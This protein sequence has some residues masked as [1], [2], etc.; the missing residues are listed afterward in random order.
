M[1]LQTEILICYR[2]RLDLIDQTASSAAES[3]ASS[4]ESGGIARPDVNDQ[5][6]QETNDF[7]D[8]QLTSQ[9]G[10]PS[11]SRESLDVGHGSDDEEAEIHHHQACGAS[12]CAWLRLQQDPAAQSYIKQHPRCYGP[13]RLLMQY[14]EQDGRQYFQ[15][16]LASGQLL[17]FVH[18][19]VSKEDA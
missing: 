16:S 2:R 8:Q 19:K 13:E 7:L 5:R 15:Y 17:R 4:D 14:R 1:V 3:A 6:A 12:T 10:L 9:Y 18:S 11:T